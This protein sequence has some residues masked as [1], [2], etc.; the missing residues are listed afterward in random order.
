MLKT[1]KQLLLLTLTW[2]LAL[3]S[4]LYAKPNP[5]QLANLRASFNEA[6]NLRVEY[7][8]SSIQ[9]L[10]DVYERSLVVPDTQLAIRSLMILS[11]LY[12]HKANYSES[13]NRLWTA[14]LLADAAGKEQGKAS[15]YMALGRYY[16]FYYR[17]KD[18]VENLQ[19]SLNIKK[20]LVAKGKL[21]R[22]QL[23]MNYH[24]F[25][26]T[27]REL[28]KPDLSKVYLD[29]SFYFYSPESSIVSYSLLKFEEAVL[30]NTHEEYEKALTIFHEILPWFP[31]NNPGY[32]VL[33]YFYLGNTYKGLADFQESE[34]CYKKALEISDTYN[35][36]I[37]FTP[38]VYQ[39][40]AAL[41]SFKGE[42]QKA[43]QSLIQGQELD[44]QIFDS[45]SESNRPLLEIQ[46]EFRQS[47]E[48]QAK[49]IQEQK[50]AQLEQEDKILLLQ[51][52]LLIG[53]LA[54]L[55]LFGL[56]YFKQVKSKHRSE[57]ELLQKK[58]ELEALKTKELIELKN[59]EMAASVLKLIEKETFIN[60]LREKLEQGK[61]DL[62]RH[63]ISQIL[64]AEASNSDKNWKR[65]ET[66]F[67][68]VNASFYDK[69]NEKFPGLTQGDLKIC[70]LV[71]LNFTSKE[72]AKLL[73]MS[74]ES[75]H[76]TRSRLRKKL[77]LSRGTNLV[78]FIANI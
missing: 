55:I 2:L 65:F 17:E 29:S 34:K 60:T 3:S 59:K 25:C 16:S 68:A 30:H 36:H 73:D 40:L 21:D 70:A 75:V 28:N 63:E 62:K 33:V 66:R 69:L 51:R 42:H 10:H 54:F 4:C 5:T 1:T 64:H 23:A 35:S 50:M 49:L 61:G 20:T 31:E 52:A 44:K 6:R 9:I 48:L 53:S 26:S 38:L 7:P 47:K 46:D 27:Y 41:Y 37:D 57:K 56:L 78:E 24:G 19:K 13:Y 11:Q 14:L 71:K 67:I 77:K 39:Q 45:R 15:I 8:D 72:M 32:Q 74:V 12:G 43:Y 58:Q 18:A 76:T 22:A